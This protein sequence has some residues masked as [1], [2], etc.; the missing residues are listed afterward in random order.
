MP[1]FAAQEPA[2]PPQAPVARQNSFAAGGHNYF[3]AGAAFTAPERL[4][5]ANSGSTTGGGPSSFSTWSMGRLWG[6]SGA[7]DQAQQPPQ[8][9]LSTQ[10]TGSEGLGKDHLLFYGQVRAAAD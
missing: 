2:Q 1:S 5:S 9:Q 3:A 10:R 4:G 7:P 6:G 8:R